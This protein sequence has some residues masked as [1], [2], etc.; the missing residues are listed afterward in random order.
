MTAKI[1][2]EVDGNPWGNEAKFITWVRGVLRK[3]WGVHPLKLIY[4]NERKVKV[5]NENPRSMKAHPEVFKIQCE[6]CLSM[7]SPSQIEIDHEGEYQ[8]K[9]T[10]MDD[11][12]GY[13]EHLYMIDMESIRCVCKTCHKAIS[14]SQKLGVSFEEAVLLKEVIRIC[15][16]E[17]IED[18]VAFCQDYEYDDNSSAA[19]RKKNVEQILRSV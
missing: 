13:A 3:G 8:G 15:K 6:K 11:I 12:Q 17:S 16:E 5:K 10:C 14:H 4:K 9:F 7:V 18:I 2:W 19:K 1:P